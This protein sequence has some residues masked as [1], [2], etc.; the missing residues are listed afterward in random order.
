MPS[1][2][3]PNLRFELTATGEQAGTWG[4]TNNVNIGTLIEQAISGVAS[5]TMIDADKTL[6]AANGASDEARNAA[7]ILTGPLTA[8][9]N[10]IVPTVSK[11]YI[12][13]NSTAGGQSIVVKTSSGTGV[14][15]ANGLTVTVYCDGTNVLQ[16]S[17]QYNPATNALSVN[18]VGSLT[19]NASTATNVTG[20]VA[21]ANGGTGSTTPSA[22]RS[23]LGATTVGSD[24][25]TAANASAARSALVA[26]GSGAVGSSGLTMNT[27][28]LLGRTTAA[29][30]AVEEI[31]VGTGLAMS[32]GTLS[33]TVSSSGQLLNVQVF[34]S[35]GTYTRT[36]G[37]T[38]AVV[39]AVGGGG[40]SGGVRSDGS[41]TFGGYGGAG[42]TTSFGSHVS[43]A[44]GGGGG[45][46]DS[47]DIDGGSGGSGGS[48][49]TIAIRG[50]WG[51]GSHQSS[52]FFGGGPGGGGRN[53]AGQRGGGGG[54]RFNNNSGISAGGGQGETAI[55]YITSGLNATEAVTIGAGGAGG[56]SGGGSSGGPGLAGG[57]GYVIVYEYS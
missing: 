44:G 26:A 54:P 12:V 6:V 39:V 48:G 14:T 38:R 32:A 11:I 50:Q 49:A 36:S 8:T 5:I 30:G 19:G 7:I 16:A 41:P 21:V 13:R 31:S 25:F 34:T 33:S 46:G 2:Y 17:P 52:S 35:T 56:S 57:A 1:T 23:A 51:S 22:A 43:A 18:V 53:V 37:A 3:S 15:V 42:G 28:R 55:R 47:G 24:V 10:V 4:N 27:A 29:S 40:G 9:R 20:V 45:D